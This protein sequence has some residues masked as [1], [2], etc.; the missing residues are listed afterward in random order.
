MARTKPHPALAP[1]I[2]RLPELSET[3]LREV[4]ASGVHRGMWRFVLS[5]I[6][7]WIALAVAL[8]VLSAAIISAA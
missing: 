4:I 6:L 7:I 8:A 3:Q 5:S 1:A 2:Q